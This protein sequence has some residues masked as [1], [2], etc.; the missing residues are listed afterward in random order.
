MVSVSAR[1]NLLTVHYYNEFADGT[2]TEGAGVLLFNDDGKVV[3]VPALNNTGATPM[4]PR[5]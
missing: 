2:K 4:T 3:A 5:A 1:N